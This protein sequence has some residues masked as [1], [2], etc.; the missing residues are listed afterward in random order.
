MDN[1]KFLRNH[2]EIRMSVYK[3]EHMFKMKEVNKSAAKKYP[4]RKPVEWT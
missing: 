3:T 4:K 1:A 2:S